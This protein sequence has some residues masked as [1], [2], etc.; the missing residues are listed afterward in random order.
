MLKFESQNQVQNYINMLVGYDFLPLS[1]LP[2]RITRSS[3]TLID[4]MLVRYNNKT[5]SSCNDNGGVA[6]VRPR[7]PPGQPHRK[8]LGT[9]N[10][11]TLF[12]NPVRGKTSDAT[13]APE[14]HSVLDIF[15]LFSFIFLM[16]KSNPTS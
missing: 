14:G 11:I 15:I 9:C 12:L 10:T 7:R 13:P 4:H 8:T 6:L 3:A 16:P 5:L 1:T 2:T